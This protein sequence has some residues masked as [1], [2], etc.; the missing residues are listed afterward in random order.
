[1]LKKTIGNSGQRPANTRDYG[2]KP[3]LSDRKASCP[4]GEKHLNGRPWTRGNGEQD[5]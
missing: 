5:R 3:Q 1:M 2:P 4:K